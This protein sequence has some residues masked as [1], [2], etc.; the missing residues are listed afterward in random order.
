MQQ[1]FQTIKLPTTASQTTFTGGATWLNP[2][3][4]LLNDGNNA[5]IG[6]AGSGAASL[7]GTGFDFDFPPGAVI[8]GIEVLIDSPYQAGNWSNIA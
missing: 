8:D 1:N 6:L 2:T 7:F 5:T 4:I 3:N